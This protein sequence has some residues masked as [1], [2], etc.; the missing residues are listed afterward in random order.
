M[1]C[2][3]L[4]MVLAVA[5]QLIPKERPERQIPACT[6]Y[7]GAQYLIDRVCT[8]DWLWI[9]LGWLQARTVEAGYTLVYAITNDGHCPP[10]MPKCV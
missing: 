8:Y 2:A 3:H 7:F 1:P 9:G 6:R 5:R 4:L 10:G